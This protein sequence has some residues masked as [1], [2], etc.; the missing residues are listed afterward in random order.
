MN[1][2]NNVFMDY[3]DKFVVVFIDDILI[4]S[5]DEEEHA[6][7]LRLVLEKLR[8]H[9]L[10]AKFSKCEFWLKEVTFLGHVISA[11]GVAVDPAKVEAAT[12]WKA[13]KS[14]TEIRSFLGLAGYYRRFIEGFSKI[15]RPMTQL[16]KKEKKF[17]WSEQCQESFEQLKEKLTS[18]PILVLPDNRKDFVIY[19]DASRQGLGGVLMQDG[20]VVAYASR[21]L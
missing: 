5:K 6:E 13:P 10:Y 19:C 11:G 16:L 18:A 20:K 2:M 15:A 8:K 3:L 12:E 7:H 14:V 17:V 21:Q 9:K 1:L 4:Y